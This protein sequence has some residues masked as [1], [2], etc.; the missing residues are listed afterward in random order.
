MLR[1][2]GVEELITADAD[3]Y[4]DLAI[5]LAADRQRRDGLRRQLIATQDRL[6]TDTRVMPALTAFLENAAI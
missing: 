4:V 1:L 2:L 5:A 3:G 6:F